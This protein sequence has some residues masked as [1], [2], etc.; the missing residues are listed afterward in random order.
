MAVLRKLALRGLK[1][2]I[3]PYI[4]APMKAS[5]L[6][7]SRDNDVEDRQLAN[8]S[9][10][11]RRAGLIAAALPVLSMPVAFAQGA[12]AAAGTAVTTAAGYTLAAPVVT[13]LQTAGPAAFFFLQLS[14]SAAVRQIIKDKS[15]GDMSLLPFISLFTNCVVWSWYGHL[16][17]DSTVFLPNFSGVGFGL[18]YTAVYLRYA[19]RSQLPMLLGSGALVSSVSAAAMML[20]ADQVA[21]YIGYLGNAVAVV[22]MTSPLAVMKTVLE[23]KST[24]AMPFPQSLA[25]FCSATCWAGYGILVAGDPLIWFPNVLGTVAATVQLGLFA[26]FGIA[27]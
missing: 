19:T 15:T 4:Q 17:D 16:I 6:W 11:G 27:K 23:Q 3:L 22:L 5:C 9:S 2:Q 1:R 7:M 12:E 13:F 26:R 10:F 14:G 20:P 24:K 25:T 8:A 18:V 21:P